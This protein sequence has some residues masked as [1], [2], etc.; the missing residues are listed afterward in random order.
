[1]SRISDHFALE[2]WAD[3]VR[4]QAAAE[5]APQMQGHLDRGCAA[6][7]RAAALWQRVKDVARRERTYSPPDGDFR[8]ARALFSC[9]TPQEWQTRTLRMA[10]LLG[11]GQPLSMGLRGLGASSSHYLFQE[12]EVSVDVQFENKPARGEASIVGQISHSSDP[13]QRY[14]ARSV[15]LRREQEIVANSTSG[16]FGEFQFQFTPRHDLL[17][18]IELDRTSY[19][20]SALPPLTES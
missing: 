5:V 11:H 14:E 9:F 16:E 18:V 6:C 7:S 15:S 3:F 4:G 8:R 2:N 10:H 17:L 12:G 1:M 20:I 13:L 19:L